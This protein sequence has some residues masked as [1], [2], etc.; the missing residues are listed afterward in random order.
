MGRGVFGAMGGVQ[1]SVS[2][3]ARWV[4]FLLDA[5]PA[6]NGA[7]RGSVRRSSVRELAKLKQQVGECAGDAPIRA[8]GV[9]SGDFEWTCERSAVNGRMLLSPSN[10]PGIQA[11]R[12]EGADKLTPRRGPTPLA[13]AP[14][15]P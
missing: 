14:I 9:L 8:T 11:L 5:W 13:M 6:R 10:P 3:C 4:A 2:D 12:L 7:E 1:T 15:A